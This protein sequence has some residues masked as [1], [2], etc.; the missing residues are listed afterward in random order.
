MIIKQFC[1][2]YD[3]TEDQFYGREE[4]SGSLC[5]ESLTSIPEGFN[6]TVGGF[7]YLKYKRRY[8][9][10]AVS[11]PVNNPIISWE[12]GKYISAD[13][14][15]C[16]VISHKGM[17]YK[18]RKLF[19]DDAFYVVEIDGKVAHGKTIKEAKKDLLYK[20]SNRDTSR[21][22]GMKISDTLT[23]AEGIEMY[24]VITGACAFGTKDYVENRIPKRKAKY[25]IGEI[26]TMTKGEY[27]N[28]KL[29]AFFA[30]K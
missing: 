4:Y 20:I 5:L 30:G 23:H 12:N 13:D 11:V 7:L 14:I 24:R 17:V 3:L 19:S 2:R 9:G 10:A 15:F 29:V 28:E 22:Q 21:Y 8:I 18:C 25:T 26:I 27:G 1:E 6:P 16:E